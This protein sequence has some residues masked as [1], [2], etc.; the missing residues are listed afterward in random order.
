MSQIMYENQD[1][2]SSEG[3]DLDE[4]FSEDERE[5]AASE[6]SSMFGGG[7][8][9]PPPQ[10]ESNGIRIS[11]L[12]NDSPRPWYDYIPVELPERPESLEGHIKRSVADLADRLKL[13]ELFKLAVLDQNLHNAYY[14]SWVREANA[15]FKL[16][17]KLKRR[18][19]KSK[20]PS[21]D[22]SGAG[23]SG[24]AD[25][26]SA[27]GEGLDAAGEIDEMQETSGDQDGDGQP[28]DEVES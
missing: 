3:G 19:A 11:E 2:E 18:L 16:Q 13:A 5:D 23:Y 22:E 9:E 26:N 20:P 4:I 15:A 1:V 28:S 6:A 10:P 21:E 7:G 14:R 12:S 27:V 8:G 25:A 24:D 17:V